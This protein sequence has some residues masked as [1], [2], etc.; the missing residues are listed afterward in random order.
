MRTRILPKMTNDEVETYLDH[1]DLI[2][3]PVGVIETHGCL[4]VNCET[5]LPEAIALKLAELSNGLC[6]TGLPYFYAGATLVGRGTVQV[7]I[8]TG[9]E[10]L[11][12]LARSLLSQ[13]FRRQVYITFHGPAMLTVGPMIRDFFEETKAP[14]LYIDGT[15]F[16]KVLT[17]SNNMIGTEELTDIFVGA[18][19]IMGCLE[20]VPVNIPESD[21]QI[22]GE[23]PRKMSRGLDFAKNIF[24][25]GHG[26]GTVGYY[27]D[28]PAEHG[29]VMP[30]P[31]KE[32]RAERAERGA[33]MIEKMTA[34]VDILGVV[35]NLARLDRHINE[36]VIPKRTNLGLK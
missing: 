11:H 33:K 4:P 9:T 14:I 35:E 16:L 22:Y 31:T 6:L 27:F 1:N 10:Y 26:S 17:G 2:F 24:A 13:G 12:H 36:E 7:S 29:N 34:G 5:I 20:D 8:K 18:Y 19:Q 15:A 25:L 21:S 23:D 30:I 28:R 32:N 3:I